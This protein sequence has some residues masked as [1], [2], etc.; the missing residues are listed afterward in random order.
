M[1]QKLSIICSLLNDADILFLD[2]PTLGLDF[3]AN[4][5]LL[6]MI[7]MMTTERGKT[8][9]LTSHQ[10]EVVSILADNILLLDKGKISY[11]GSYENFIRENSLTIYEIQTEK[12]K[13]DFENQEA[14][15]QK[16]EVLI[17]EKQKI[18]SFIEKEKSIDEILISYYEG[19]NHV[20][21]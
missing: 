21:G 13:Y 7:K 6:A 11:L 15:E 5:E 18:I 2:E 3:K 19:E 12:E 17:T 16:L 14:A 10:A 8:V 4:K 9:I 20:Q 1:K